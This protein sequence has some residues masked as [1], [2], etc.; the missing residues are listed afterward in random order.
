MLFS[1]H[2]LYIPSRYKQRNISAD[3]NPSGRELR[4][5]YVRG[6]FKARKTGVFFWS[7]YRRGSE[8]LGCI[9]KDYALR[10]AA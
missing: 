2:L 4:A 5:H 6:H 8:K 3:G 7:A 1:Y 9:H 10:R